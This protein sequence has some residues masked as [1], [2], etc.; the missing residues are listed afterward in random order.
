MDSHRKR[1]SPATSSPS[2]PSSSEPPRTCPRCDSPN[3]KFCYYNNYSSAQPRYFCRTCRRYWTHGGALRNLPHASNA[4]SRRAAKLSR[5]PTP[6]SNF[7]AAAG[8]AASTSRPPLHHLQVSSAGTTSLSAPPWY[9]A[10]PTFLR[11]PMGQVSRPPTVLELSPVLP[12]V[13]D[14]V[15]NP[16][17]HFLRPPL[18]PSAASAGEEG[19]RFFSDLFRGL[20]DGSGGAAAVRRTP[21]PS[22][23]PFD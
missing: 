17:G 19:D 10:G 9:F 4:A 5:R 2:K 18:L 14:G 21:P 1:K 7:P 22:S 12:A 16:A 20:Q 11:Q 8:A 13:M 15:Q 3:T 23:G 6:S